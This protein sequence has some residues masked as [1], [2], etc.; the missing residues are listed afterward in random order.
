MAV[1][2]NPEILKVIAFFLMI[3]DIVKIII[4]IAL[5]VIG[6]IDFSK[7][8]ISSDESA[9]KK[10]AT[11]FGKRLIYAVLVFIAPWMIEVVMTTLG[12]LL[13]KEGMT[14]FTDCI[15]NSENIFYYEQLANIKKEEEK[16]EYQANEVYFDEKESST[17]KNNT[18]GSKNTEGTII[19]QKYNLTEQQL[20]GIA[21]LCQKEQGSAIGAAAEASLIANRFE[22][23][24]SKY[25]TG[26]DG[27][28]NYVR[29]SKW[30]ANGQ[31]H[32]DNPEGLKDSV[33]TAVY[34]VLILGQRTLPLYIDEHDCIKCGKSFDIIKIETD[35]QIITDEEGRLN[36]NN[37]IQH[38]TIIYNRYTS[39]YTFYTFPTTESDPFG[40]HIKAKN[41]YDSLN[42]K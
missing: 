23:Y 31:K 42:G 10:S 4:P 22:L 13:G 11:L 26:A 32:T 33:Y 39:V 2:T 36:R 20:R 24:G 7:A 16:K 28:Y 21:K 27:L 5:I 12:D 41:K 34:N 37:Y 29:N 30:W 40:Y 8:V 38:K 19:G 17:I 6:I 35:N 14:N 9:Q 25:G 15:T 3:I 18:T 1:C